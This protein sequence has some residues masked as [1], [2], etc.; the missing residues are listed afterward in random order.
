MSLAPAFAVC[1]SILP[2]LFSS[3]APA[4]ASPATEDLV[5]GLLPDTGMTRRIARVAASLP[6]LCQN[7][8]IL[9]REIERAQQLHAGHKIDA[10]RTLISNRIQSDFERGRTITV[11]GWLLAATEVEIVYL[12]ST[13]RPN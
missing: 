4:T 5:S 1:L 3:I 6:G 12:A 2:A 9:G 10:V 7:A 13:Y 8:E 11:D